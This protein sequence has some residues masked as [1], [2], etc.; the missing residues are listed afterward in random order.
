[1]F[2]QQIWES[3]TPLQ[4]SICFRAC[5]AAHAQNTALTLS[6]NGAALKRLQNEGVQVRQFSD[7]VWDAFGRASVEV[8]EENMGDP[9]YA[10]IAESYFASMAESAGWY[11][12]ADGEFM[13]QRNRVN[14]G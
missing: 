5:E 14:A 8:R 11:E 4:Q 12:I 9:I 1:V 10:K 13:R 7:D 6:E 2:N 3:L